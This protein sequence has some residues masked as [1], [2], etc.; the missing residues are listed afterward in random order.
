MFVKKAKNNMVDRN[1]EIRKINQQIAPYQ[2]VR[3]AQIDEDTYAAFFGE[4][5]I[6]DTC[7]NL[8]ELVTR[9]IKVDPMF[10][11]NPWE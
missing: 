8:E 3:F 7:K 10:Q 9:T 5:I 2:N 1:D 6:I 11:E 4:K